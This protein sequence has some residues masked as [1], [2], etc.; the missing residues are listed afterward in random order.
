MKKV[1][2]IL[3][4]LVTALALT[5]CGISKI[6]EISLSSVD[7]AYVVPTSGRSLD[8]KLLLGI[9][10]PAMGFIVQEVSGTLRYNDKPIAL[11][12]TTGP[13]VL[14][15]KCD[16]VYEVPCT[17]SLAEGASIL[18]VMMLAG[19]RSLDGFWADVDV[20]ASRKPGGKWYGPIQFR[21]IELSSYSFSSL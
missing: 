21:D 16:A 15:G 9:N 18:E 17:V 4:L 7:V 20:I 14:Q 5:G 6:K 10:N 12:K 1:R 3:L 11:F 8:G 2:H 19:R 13:V